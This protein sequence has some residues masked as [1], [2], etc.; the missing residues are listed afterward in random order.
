M[1]QKI[2]G[3]GKTVHVV[4]NIKLYEGVGS[5]RVAPYTSHE[6]ASFWMPQQAFEEG[7]WK[8]F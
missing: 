3:G 4:L 7:Y 2:R 8:D 1:K 5:G 6:Q